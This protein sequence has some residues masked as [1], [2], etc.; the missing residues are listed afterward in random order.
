MCEIILCYP[1]CWRRS[2][3]VKLLFACINLQLIMQYYFKYE[4]NVTKIDVGLPKSVATHS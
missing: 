4:P 2:V 3:D 1:N